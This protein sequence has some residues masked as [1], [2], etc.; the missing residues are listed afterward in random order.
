MNLD[1]L[2]HDAFKILLEGLDG[3]KRP[4]VMF[5]GGKD[6]VVMLHL[7]ARRFKIPMDIIFH[8][9]PFFSWKH[10]FG[11][12]VLRTFGC[13]SFDWLP[14]SVALWEGREIMAF[15]NFYN[16]NSSGEPLGTLMLPKNILEPEEGK[17]W[18][19]GRDAWFR[20]PLG[21]IDYQ[22]DCAI[23]G[24]KSTDKDQIAG[25][26]PLHVNSTK[27]SEE[28]KV[29]F[30]LRNWTD[31][32]IWDY[33][34]LF[35]LPVDIAR[36]NQTLRKEHINKHHNPDYFHACIACMDRRNKSETVHCPKVNK[37]IPNISSTIPYHESPTFNY[38]GVKEPSHV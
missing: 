33:T 20:R 18:L 31:S 1:E 13:Y 27:V 32:D 6:S 7:I 17:P 4:A 24:H 11:E 19:C 9:E 35:E 5:S 29:V 34:E 26:V 28:M 8:K 15:T 38:Y 12:H 21:G 3:V 2:I 16:I 36:Y 14:C 23:I 37:L 22:W 25:E 30:P 10:D